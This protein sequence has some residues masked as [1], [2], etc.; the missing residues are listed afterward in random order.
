MAIRTDQMWRYARTVMIGHYH[1]DG[2]YTQETWEPV[3]KVEPSVHQ[4]WDFHLEDGC[5]LQS[6]FDDMEIDVKMIPH[7]DV[8]NWGKAPLAIRTEYD[9]DG[10]PI[11]VYA[12]TF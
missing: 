1:G 10:E 5:K 7:P 9:A 3:V 8:A 6:C 4:G 12:V 2:N 11:A